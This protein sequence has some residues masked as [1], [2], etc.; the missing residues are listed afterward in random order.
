[1]KT[2][3]LHQIQFFEIKKSTIIYQSIS[4]IVNQLFVNYLHGLINS[5]HQL[6]VFSKDYHSSPIAQLRDYRDMQYLIR[7]Q[8]YLLHEQQSKSE[9]LTLADQRSQHIWIRREGHIVGAM[10]ATPMPYELSFLAPSDFLQRYCPANYLEFGRLVTSAANDV[11]AIS[12][13]LIASAC[14]HGVTHQFAGVV[15][16]CKSPQ[17]RLF[18]RFGLTA[19]PEQFTVAERNDGKYWLLIASWADI[20]NAIPAEEFALYNQEHKALA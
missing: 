14:L 9:Q 8:S 15:A 4:I 6:T 1:M 16:M 5:Q 2:S 20:I 17:R 13:T 3:G 11:A 7:G 18:E 10:R 12:R 19:V